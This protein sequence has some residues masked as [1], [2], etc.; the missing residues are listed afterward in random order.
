M[1]VANLI[2]GAMDNRKR[3]RLH[4][5]GI[6]SNIDEDSG[7]PMPQ[8]RVLKRPAARGT[9]DKCT[10]PAFPETGDPVHYREGVIYSD[11]VAKKVQVL[12][13]HGG[14]CRPQRQLRRQQAR[15]FR[16]GART[17][18][19]GLRLGRAAQASRQEVL[20][21]SCSL[22]R[23]DRSDWNCFAVKNK[24]VHGGACACAVVARLAMKNVQLILQT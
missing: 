13:L 11:D 8:T 18:G 10:R 20:S 22:E 2:L 3:V 1:E 23:L 21:A 4:K 7:G 14:L 6:D 9:G 5:D 24:P 17:H 16:E 15:R 12:L 19:R